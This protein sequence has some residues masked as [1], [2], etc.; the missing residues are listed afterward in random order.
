[1]GK[2]EIKNV[3]SLEKIMP[4]MN[5]NAA[6]FDKGSALVDEVFSYQ[7]A[8][9][10]NLN[11]HQGKELQLEICSDI[12]EC[13]T[14][15][16]IRYVPV[17]MNR[18]RDEPDDNY[19][20]E[21][22][23]LFPDVLE[24]YTDFVPVSSN[25]YGAVWVD[26]KISRRT[27]PGIYSIKIVFKDS[28][29]NEM[30]AESNFE[31]EVI[32]A[33][34]PKLDIPYAHWMYCDCISSYYGCEIFSERHWTLIDN[35][36]R[37]A[38]ENGVNMMLTPV[39]TPPLDTKIGAERPT[40]QLV[41]VTYVSGKYRF[42]F[43]KLLRWFEI[44]K[45]NHIEYIEISHLFSQWGAEYAPKIEVTE[46][47]KKI[48]KFGRHAGSLDEN[49]KDFLTQF[50][51]ELKGV[52][53][54][55]WNKEKVYFHISDEP[56]EKHIELYG[57]IYNFVKP[58]FGDFKQMD[59]MS[60]YELFEKGFIETP[61]VATTSINSFLGKG[62][63]NLWVYYC[64]GQGKSNLSNRFIAMPSYRNRIMGIQLYRNDIKGFLQWG[65]NFYYS[66]QST[67]M[68]NPYLVTDGE[69][70]FPAGDAFSVY[71]GTDG[72]LE[73]IRIKVFKHGLQDFMAL[74]LLENYIGKDAVQDIVKD[75]ESFSV[76][77]N[78]AE[79]ILKVRKAV[80]EFIKDEL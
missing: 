73:S 29:N 46:N 45:K 57:K 51:P 80:N 52:L 68:I 21:C 40:I 27:N 72:P 7:I 17:I 23:G 48:K 74:K 38:A 33:K 65:Y 14:L 8:F 53:E 10:S 77:P 36:M 43:K 41:D 66:Q 44:C 26:I 13:I 22:P 18:F 16:N 62:I 9:K 37:T 70:A 32:G 34:L 39:F 2:L 58:L 67:H 69:Y 31:L 24:P 71:P 47:G 12:A 79:Y 50:I 54:K 5:C 19:I 42:N 28:D 1:M 30:W 6:A 75:V 25:T 59:A 63:K 76:Y 56:N 78:N 55:N 4:N 3:S 20:S 11:L 61:I 60:D 64:C 35:Y 49:Y 15:Y